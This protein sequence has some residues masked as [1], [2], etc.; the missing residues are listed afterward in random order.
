VA[1]P[2]P[3][4]WYADPE[5]GGRWR[6]WDG[7]AWTD[8]T[9]E[10]RPPASSDSLWRDQLLYVRTH[11]SVGSFQATVLTSDG[12]EIAWMT[13]GGMQMHLSNV[14]FPIVDAARNTLL[15][16][17]GSY[18]RASPT[19]GIED[20]SG[21][22]FGEVE[23]TRFTPRSF[24]FQLTSGGQAIGELRSVDWRRRQCVAVDASGTEVA[25]TEQ[26]A[27]AR[28]QFLHVD[29]L[30]S[31]SLR[32]PLPEAIDRVTLGLLIGLRQILTMSKSRVGRAGGGFQTW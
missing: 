32:R 14:T 31:I 15:V 21:R 17:E 5:D 13:S 19:I 30:Y 4:G 20:G 25:R 24:R 3:A 8:H 2:P 11:G 23:L 28:T 7:S 1:E 9:S 26:A 16:L 12:A 22:R 27:P 29:D 18:F 10:P 6:W